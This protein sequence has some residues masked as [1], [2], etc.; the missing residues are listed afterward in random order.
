MIVA[1][2]NEF[3]YKRRATSRSRLSSPGLTFVFLHLS[4]EYVNRFLGRYN[5]TK[6]VLLYIY[7]ARYIKLGI[8]T[9]PLVQLGFRFYDGWDAKLCAAVRR[10]ALVVR[11]N[12]F[13]TIS[14]V[15]LLTLIFILAELT[16]LTARPPPADRSFR[17]ALLLCV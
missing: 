13:Y 6:R 16:H 15:D 5:T 9:V 17:Y 12:F 1:A 4:M 14:A 8:S 11:F 10:N 2:A 3:K 7:S